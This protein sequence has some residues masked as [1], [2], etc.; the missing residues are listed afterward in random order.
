VTDHRPRRPK[1]TLCGTK[2]R[3]VR[4]LR[5]AG[6]GDQAYDDPDWA[7]RICTACDTA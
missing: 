1:C 3:M 7:V 4:V 2:R 5:R 6:E